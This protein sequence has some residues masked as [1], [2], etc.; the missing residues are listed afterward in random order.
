MRM[1]GM[2][3]HVY[4]SKAN[5]KDDLI[6]QVVSVV[7]KELVSKQFVQPMV[8]IGDGD[9]DTGMAR[10]AE[11]AIGFGGVRNIAP[12]LLR[13]IDFAFYDEKECSAF[14]EELL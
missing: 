12:S 9:N 8:V 4:C 14:L 6:T 5:V 1:I 13:N 10:M 3:N 11:I 7:D 2:E